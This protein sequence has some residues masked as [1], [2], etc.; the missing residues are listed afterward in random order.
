VLA[1]PLLVVQVGAAD[2]N[3]YRHGGSA[4]LHGT[5]LYAPSFAAGLRT[6]LPFTYPPFAAVAAIVLLAVPGPLCAW[7]WGI[8]TILLLAWCLRVA[9]G[10]LLESGRFPPDLALAVVTALL[11]Y[12]RPV[13][14]HLGDGQV[15]ILLMAMCLADC[16]ISRPRWPRGLLVG[17]AAAIKLVPGIFIPYLWLTGRRRA[18]AVAAGTFVACQV[19]AGLLA[20]GDSHRYWTRLMFD[21]ERPGYTAGY[22]N[23]SLRGVGLRLL[24]ASGRTVVLVAIAVIIVVIGLTRARQATCRGA[25]V[26]GATLTGLVGVLA[27][28]VSWIHA[29]VWV[30]PAIG[31][32]VGRLASP[33]RAGA[34]AAIAV[35]LLAALPY[36]PNVVHSLPRPE[37]EALQASFGLMCLLL[38]MTLPTAPIGEVGPRQTV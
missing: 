34:A 14:D 30:L 8:A 7:L 24:P 20:F 12:T 37:V 28:P 19:V 15:D 35:A 36:I 29:T 6:H 27:S 21:T 25:L 32:V 3:V 31:I 23:Q 2:L 9:F 1:A 17:L 22:K 13:F 16:V 11:L 4:I 10:P 38:V 26:A 18:A 33:V 5:S